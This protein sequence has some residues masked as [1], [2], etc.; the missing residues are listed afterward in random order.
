MT[1]IKAVVFRLADESVLG[2]SLHHVAF[3]GMSSILLVKSIE[4][5][6]AG[7]APLAQPADNALP[8]PPESATALY[9]EM[10]PSGVPVCEMPTKVA[11]AKAHPV[12]DRE[13]TLSWTPGES[14][15]AFRCGPR[16]GVLPTLGAEGKLHQ[17]R[18]AGVGHQSFDVF[19][20]GDSAD[21]QLD[22]AGL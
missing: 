15:S 14:R 13:L 4:S 17:G 20:M 1:P 6:L 16:S 3:D 19:R 21:I 7:G 11:R 22:L 2:L 8:A 18:W 10:F 5:V 9:D 12:E